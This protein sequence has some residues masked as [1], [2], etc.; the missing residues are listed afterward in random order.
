MKIT[1]RK[2]TA[3]DTK[4]W[5]D[6]VNQS[7]NGTIFHYRSFLT[8]HIDREFEDHSLIFVKKGKIIAVLSAAEVMDGSKKVLCSHP[9]ASFGSLVYKQLLSFKE[10]MNIGELLKNYANENEFNTITITMPPIIYSVVP[11]DYFEFSLLKIGAYPEKSEMSSVVNLNL[12]INE[13]KANI[14]SSH[15]QAE[16]KAERHGIIIKESNDYETF[17]SILVRNLEL[18]HEVRPTHTLTELQKLVKLFPEQIILHTAYHKDNMIAGIVNFV[19]NDNTVLAFYICHDHQYQDYRPLNLLFLH[20]FD[21]VIKGGYK[22]YDFGIFTVNEE[23]NYGLAR[24]KE[25]FGANGYFRKTLRID[26]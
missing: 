2:F 19:C 18:R 3:K 8:Y 23:P 11:S 7:N 17:Y 22:F 16:R 1:V 6:F 24:F 20:I 21:W 10:A 9:G 4:D 14:K 12:S 15:R 5:D 13:I 26:I 25:N